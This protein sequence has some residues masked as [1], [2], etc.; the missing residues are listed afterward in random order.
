MLVIDNG[1]KIINAEN[2]LLIEESPYPVYSGYLV[3]ENRSNR[4]GRMD[5]IKT[6][7]TGTPLILFILDIL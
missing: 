6:D 4:M 2:I 7:S 3:R 1:F 5:R